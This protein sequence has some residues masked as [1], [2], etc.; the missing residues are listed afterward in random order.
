[1]QPHVHIS[2]TQWRKGGNLG[3]KSKLDSGP[4]PQAELVGAS[5]KQP[6]PGCSPL[7][8]NRLK[9]PGNQSHI[10]PENQDTLIW[11]SGPPG[12]G[13]STTGQL[14]SRNTGFVYYEADCVMNHANPYVP[15]DVENPSFA[16]M[17]QKHLKVW[18]SVQTFILKLQMIAQTDKI[19]THFKFSYIF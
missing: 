5:R 10:Q 3:W 1:M 2:H 17:F 14:L 7:E 19:Y 8:G 4:G 13:K 18:S 15:A 6:Q 11:I 12:A 9:R 16:Q